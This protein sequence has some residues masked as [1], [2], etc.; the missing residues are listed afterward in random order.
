MV[1]EPSNLIVF[2]FLEVFVF[3]FKF[4]YS[5]KRSK[6]FDVFTETIVVS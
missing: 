3:I 6:E 1:K 2:T 5:F 4:C